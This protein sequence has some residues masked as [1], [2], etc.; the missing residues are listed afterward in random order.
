MSAVSPSATHCMLSLGLS[1]VSMSRHIQ[2]PPQ[3]SMNS[4]NGVESSVAGG[5]KGLTWSLFI[6]DSDI[7]IMEVGIPAGKIWAG[8]YT[9]VI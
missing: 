8:V 7:C 3:V 1:P 5:G 4:Q 6:L 9:C 2:L